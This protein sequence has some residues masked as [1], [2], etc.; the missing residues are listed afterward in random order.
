MGKVTTR[1]L[2][3]LGILLALIVLVG[4]LVFLIN[5]PERGPEVA[6]PVVLFLNEFL[7][8]NYSTTS[9]H[10]VFASYFEEW[11]ADAPNSLEEIFVGVMK[12]WSPGY[13]TFEVEPI[14]DSFCIVRLYTDDGTFVAPPIGFWYTLTSDGLK[15]SDW[16]ICRLQ[17]F[18]RYDDEFSVLWEGLYGY[19]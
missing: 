6:E 2:V 11:D 7:D 16:E 15:I 19:S 13:T 12:L 1:Q 4:C 5:R 8:P 17:P 14:S 10:S 3:C 18:S 9:Q